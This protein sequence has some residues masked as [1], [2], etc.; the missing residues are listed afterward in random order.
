ME[1][2]LYCQYD[3][4][5][6]TIVIN[7]VCFRA[8]RRMRLPKVIFDTCFNSFR[9]WVKYRA[10]WKVVASG[11]A[12]EKLLTKTPSWS[13][14]R[15][16]TILAHGTCGY[17]TRFITMQG[18]LRKLASYL[19]VHLPIS[20]KAFTRHARGL[21]SSSSFNKTSRGQHGQQL[22]RAHCKKKQP[23]KRRRCKNVIACIIFMISEAS[24]TK[25][26]LVASQLSSAP[27]WPFPSHLWATD[28]SCSHLTTWSD[29]VQDLL[30]VQ[31]LRSTTHNGTITR[32]NRL[33]ASEQ[34]SYMAMQHTSQNFPWKE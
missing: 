12:A 29:K 33:Q 19:R 15:L 17:H 9:A 11:S 20:L 16:R 31:A 27:N 23:P 24:S 21:Q 10:T 34:A 26:P 3:T 30:V 7:D 14:N 25:P 13:T 6:Q 2:T 1:T 28:C 4:T 18:H 22:G 32:H 8:K 5:S